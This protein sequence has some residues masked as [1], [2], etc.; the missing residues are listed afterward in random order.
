VD[1]ARTRPRLPGGR[2]RL[3]LVAAMALAAPVGTLLASALGQHMVATRNLATSW[4]WLA[5]AIGAIIAATGTRLA[6]AA[7]ALV[8]AAFAV[9]GLELLTPNARRPDYRAAAAAIDRAAR[10]GDAVVDDGAALVTPGPLTGLDAALRGRHAIVRVGVPE[11]RV[12]TFLYGDPIAGPDAAVRRAAALAGRGTIFVLSQQGG[13]AWS[14]APWDER[15]RAVGFGPVAA[16]TFPG[17]IRLHLLAYARPGA[18]RAA[19]MLAGA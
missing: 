8:V 12:R 1:L 9:G 3:V 13:P 17:L 18:R 10:P 4:P 16:R 2:D 6:A 11:E 15:L 14:D 5:L 7:A 19:P